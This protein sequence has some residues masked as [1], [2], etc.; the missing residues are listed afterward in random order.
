HDSDVAIADVDGQLL[1]AALA[2][3]GQIVQAQSLQRRAILP[4]DLL[5]LA[6]VAVIADVAVAVIH[7]LDV[8]AVAGISFKVD[9]EDDQVGEGQLLVVLLIDGVT[10]GAV[11]GVVLLHLVG[12]G[13]VIVQEAGLVAGTVGNGHILA[14]GNHRAVL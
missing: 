8:M 13:S 3:L 11:G 7:I 9:V 2:V 1:V 6:A 10:P 4:V 12:G 5:V 14:V